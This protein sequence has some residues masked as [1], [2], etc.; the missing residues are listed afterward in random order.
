MKEGTPPK[1]PECDGAMIEQPELR[2]VRCGPPKPTEV[3]LQEL[4]ESG[5][6]LRFDAPSTH[7]AY[8][9]S[10]YV[11]GSQYT[12]FVGAAGVLFCG[13]YKPDAPGM[14]TVN[15]LP[16]DFDIA[17]DNG[18][19]WNDIRDK[20]FRILPK[21]P[22][23]ASFLWK[24]A[25]EYRMCAQ[26]KSWDQVLPKNIVRWA[27]GVLENASKGDDCVDNY[28]VARIGN[29]SQMRR[30]RSQKAHGCCGFSDFAEEGP[31][32]KRYM[33]GFNYGH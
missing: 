27:L 11:G 6:K 3:T 17:I 26:Q 5:A 7:R 16:I 8:A 1:C 30:Y 24:R 2:C 22:N 13:P 15:L 12:L 4:I 19:Y 33:M 28:R 14:G 29:T 18:S 10:I 20:I 9:R 31:D 23:F 32:G 21:Y 25:K